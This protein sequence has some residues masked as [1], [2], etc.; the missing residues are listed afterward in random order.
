[1]TVYGHIIIAHRISDAHV[2]RKLPA[3]NVPLWI[4]VIFNKAVGL[5]VQRAEKSSYAQRP[6][7]PTDP[8]KIDNHHTPTT[9][10]PHTATRRNMKIGARNPA[11]PKL[12]TRD[13]FLEDL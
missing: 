13:E 3:G 5:E 1:M 10:P 6:T 2:R 4:V 8:A 9:P 12:R 11:L 7:K